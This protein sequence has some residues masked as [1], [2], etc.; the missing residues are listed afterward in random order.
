MFVLPS[1][2]RDSVLTSALQGF[3]Q[4]GHILGEHA[5][6]RARKDA[7][8]SLSAGNLNIGSILKANL[9]PKETAA[10]L[11]HLTERGSSS[12]SSSASSSASSFPSSSQKESGLDIRHRDRPTASLSSGLTY[13]SSRTT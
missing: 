9:D 2:D 10:L 8:K 6:A 12:P 11:Q 5:S 3:A 7:I 4:S 13:P 1:N